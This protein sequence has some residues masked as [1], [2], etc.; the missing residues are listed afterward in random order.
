MTKAGTVV[1]VPGIAGTTRLFA[2]LEP[3]L[4]DAGFRVVA[5]GHE[6]GPADVDA[7]VRRADEAFPRDGVRVILGESFGGVVAQT[8]VRR[9]PTRATHL[10]LAGTFAHL[11]SR[12]RK[13]L[14]DALSPLAPALEAVPDALLRF[15]RRTANATVNAED[16]QALHDAYREEP[17]GEARGYFENARVALAFDGRPWL[18][19]VQIPTL[20]VHGAND[21][22]IPRA[23]GEE[24]AR[25]VPGAE[26][27][28]F[29][30]TGHLPHLAHPERFTARLLRFVGA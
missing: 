30:G 29:E 8:F 12:V 21:R 23:R 15:V 26:L 6:G 9:H 2:L 1:Y 3:R 22:L 11:G 18:A 25:L 4:V 24:L 16:P 5:L 10:V 7:L 14:A 17:A 28:I 27:E 20:V 19:D 13:G